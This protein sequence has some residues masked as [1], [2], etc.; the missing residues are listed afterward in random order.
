MITFLKKKQPPNNPTK[1]IPGNLNRDDTYCRRT[2]EMAPSFTNR[3]S[4]TVQSDFLEPLST[5]N[6]HRHEIEK[7]ML[8][9]FEN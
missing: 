6:S 7:E 3:P 8:T 5:H 1:T 2:E 4:K 9:L